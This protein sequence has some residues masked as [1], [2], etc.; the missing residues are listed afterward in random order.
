M[1]GVLMYFGLQVSVCLDDIE[2]CCIYSHMHFKWRGGEFSRHSFCIKEILSSIYLTHTHCK[3]LTFARTITPYSPKL[4]HIW[5]PQIINILHASFYVVVALNCLK[6]ELHEFAAK[7]HLIY[8]ADRNNTFSTTLLM[9][10][11]ISMV[12]SS[13]EIWRTIATGDELWAGRTDV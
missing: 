5:M 12:Y 13:L 10:T 2:Q 1:L 9:H 6:S 8:V 4:V 7:V 3:H 11:Y